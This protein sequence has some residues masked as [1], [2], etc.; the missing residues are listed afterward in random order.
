MNSTVLL[1]LSQVSKTLADE[2]DTLKRCAL[3]VVHTLDEWVHDARKY[4]QV[5]GRIQALQLVLNMLMEH[6]KER[7]ALAV[8]LLGRIVITLDGMRG[9][10]LREVAQKAC[11]HYLVRT[12]STEET[13]RMI[14]LESEA[15][16]KLLGGDDGE[17]PL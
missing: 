13:V 8:D 16:A 10:R 5:E 11:R 3:P 6:G 17:I 1:M 4:G 7:E 9:D 12:S 14:R 2:Q 15:V